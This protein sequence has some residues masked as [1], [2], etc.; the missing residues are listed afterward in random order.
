M[1]QI[2]QLSLSKY[3]SNL[4]IL[5]Y[6]FF[7]KDSGRAADLVA[8]LHACYCDSESG[9]GGGNGYPPRPQTGLAKGGSRESEI[10]A[11]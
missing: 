1:N 7:L 3:G 2:L 9:G 4:L 10:N 6:L 11:M 8:E 5:G